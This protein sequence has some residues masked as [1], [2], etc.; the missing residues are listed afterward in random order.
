MQ[1][2][3][4]RAFVLLKK[5][6]NFSD[7]AQEMYVSQSSFSK[8]IKALENEVGTALVDR[9][10]HRFSFTEEGEAVRILSEYEGML[11]AI[12]EASSTQDHRLR[13]SVDSAANAYIYIRSILDFFESH[14]QYELQLH[15]YDTTDALKGLE[16]GELD[17]VIGYTNLAG[18]DHPYG[19]LRLREEELY[20]VGSESSLGQSRP[21]Q[22]IALSEVIDDH[23]ILHQN[24]YREISRALEAAGI[25]LDSG[26]PIAT[27]TSMDVLRAYLQRGT[28]RSLLTQAA[29][30]ALDP[31]KD[32]VRLRICRHPAVV[33][34]LMYQKEKLNETGRELLNYV[35]AM[36]KR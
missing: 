13:I 12:Q 29:A 24:L 25:R 27:T 10:R 2:E 19:A 23:L 6:M 26:H 33:V 35:R 22:E 8:Y 1:M 32:L 14:P 36:R 20:Y 3:W 15:E 11:S 16:A 28:A 9:S 30:D 7:A 5:K 4:L 34:G 17:L 31:D 21:D 18:Q